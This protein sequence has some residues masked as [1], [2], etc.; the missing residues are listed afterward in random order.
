M[1]EKCEHKNLVLS[2]W[3]DTVQGYIVTEGWDGEEQPMGDYHIFGG[4]C[5]DCDKELT[6]QEIKDLTGLSVYIV[7]FTEI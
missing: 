7:E 3:E 6:A 2:Y 5:L 4:T 1:S